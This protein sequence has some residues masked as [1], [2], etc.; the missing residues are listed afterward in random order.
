MNASSSLRGQSLLLHR[1]RRGF[2]QRTKGPALA[3]R[4]E[5]NR[6]LRRGR[7]HR[8]HTRIRRAHRDPLLQNANVLSRQLRLRRHLQVFVLVAHAVDEQALRRLAGNQRW[9]AS[10]P[11]TQPSL[12]SSSS[13]PFRFPLLRVALIT[14]LHQQRPHACSQKT[15]RHPPPMN[16]QPRGQRG[17]IWRKD[18]ARLQ[19]TRKADSWTG[20]DRGRGVGSFR[21][22]RLLTSPASSG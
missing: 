2:L 17:A 12:R 13:P 18:G 14:M 16:Q 6:L 19:K 8:L 1:R 4:C 22:S 11:F 7:R 10:P 20:K 15:P 3:C 5:I 21:W 9:P